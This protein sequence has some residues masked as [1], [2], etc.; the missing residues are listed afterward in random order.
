MIDVTKVKAHKELG[1]DV[2]LSHNL[3]PLL[4]RATHGFLMEALTTAQRSSLEEATP[5]VSCHV[6]SQTRMQPI[7]ASCPLRLSTPCACPF[8]GICHNCPACVQ[9]KLTVSQAGDNYE[10]EADR[11]ADMV[12]NMPEPRIQRACATGSGEETAQIKPIVNQIT[13]LVQRQVESAQ[14]EEEPVQTKAV[15]KQPGAVSSAVAARIQALRGGG[16]PLLAATRAFFEPR[17]RYDFSQVRVHTD[18]WATATAQALNA[19]AFTS[20]RDVAFGV[21]EYAPGALEGQRLLAHE[22]AHVIQQRDDH[23]GAST[24]VLRKS[25]RIDQM[26][27]PKLAIYQE[28]WRSGWYFKQCAD[29]KAR[30]IRATKVGTAVDQCPEFASIGSTPYRTGKD[31]IDAILNV[32]RCTNSP[33]SQIHIYSHAGPGGVFDASGEIATQRGLYGEEHYFPRLEREKGGRTAKDIPKEA[34]AANVVFVVYG[35]NS[36]RFAEKILETILGTSPK[37]RVYGR[38]EGG[39]PKRKEGWKEFSAEQPYGKHRKKIPY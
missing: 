22:L 14:D 6:F 15:A 34:M 3:A 37:A 24:K 8:G 5:L 18:A 28:H 25:T 20:G 29:M 13:S 36:D 11:V 26:R 19:R 23:E 2:T 4:H 16:Q 30:Q 7:T 33:V 32:Y 12:M 9:A 27:N 17:F 21:S 31:I 38:P 35:C 10:E 1:A 39:D